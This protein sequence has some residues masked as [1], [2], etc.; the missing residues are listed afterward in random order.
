MSQSLCRKDKI[1][2][3]RVIYHILCCAVAVTV[4]T[5]EGKT[6]LE[7]ADYP[8]PPESIIWEQ[9]SVRKDVKEWRGRYVPFRM[10]EAVYDRKE[11][12][13]DWRLPTD[14]KY[15]YKENGYNYM[16]YFSRGRAEFSVIDDEGYYIIPYYATFYRSKLKPGEE[17]ML[18]AVVDLTRLYTMR[19][20]PR[21]EMPRL[22]KIGENEYL[23]TELRYIY[24]EKSG[25]YLRF[26]LASAYLKDDIIIAEDPCSQSKT[27]SLY[28]G[29]HPDEDAQ[30]INRRR[31]KAFRVLSRLCRLNGELF[32]EQTINDKFV[33]EKVQAV[34]D[35][36]KEWKRPKVKKYEEAQRAKYP[37]KFVYIRWGRDECDGCTPFVSDVFGLKSPRYWDEGL[38]FPNVNEGVGGMKFLKSFYKKHAFSVVRESGGDAELDVTFCVDGINVRYIVYHL[39]TYT[40]AWKEI[41]SMCVRKTDGQRREVY[42]QEKEGRESELAKGLKLNPGLVGDLD[43][44]IRRRTGE[45]G[46]LIPGS[47]RSAL[48][49]IRGNTAVG[50]FSDDPTYNALPLARAL[51]KQL[52]KGL[53]KAG[54]LLQRRQTY[55]PPRPQSPPP[56]KK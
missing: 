13:K 4:L 16:L 38:R 12:M 35:E 46:A 28:I 31:L 23:F 24:N 50:I 56:E 40:E 7:R 6:F 18:H 17:K 54:I 42:I 2:M 25:S 43:V 26:R 10:K 44:C 45:D 49:F 30:N 5:A 14:K 29:K 9:T 36:E 32:R 11:T 33:W 39:Y 15:V 48:Y 55:L 19:D 52:V 8:A 51:D 20:D 27:V 37:E 34:V 47:E 41:F 1:D 21:E 22:E 53:D 3:N